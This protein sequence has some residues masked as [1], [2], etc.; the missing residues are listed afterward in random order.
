MTAFSNLST[1]SILSDLF[2]LNLG[3]KN[4]ELQELPYNSK[5]SFH[6]VLE[7]WLQQTQHTNPIIANFARQ[8]EAEAQKF[9]EVFAPIADKSI[10]AEHKELVQLL[11]DTLFPLTEQDQWL[12]RVFQPM[13]QMD[14]YQTEALKKLNTVVP[15]ENC[16]VDASKEQAFSYLIYASSCTILNKFYGM[17]IPVEMPLILSIK[18][19]DSNLERHFKTTHD[20]KFIDVIPLGPLPELSTQKINSLLADPLN[21]SAWLEVFPPDLFEFNGVIVENLIEITEE[22]TLS[23]IK[24]QL[25]E[26]DVIVSPKSIQALEQLF[27]NFLRVSEIHLGLFAVDGK[28]AM[29]ASYKYNIHHN[30]L[31]DREDNL[32]KV[33]NSIYQKVMEAG[34]YYI[35]QDLTN[36][37]EATNI[38]VDLLNRGI[39]SIIVVP[40]YNKDQKIIGLLELASPKPFAMNNLHIAKLEEII[41]LFSIAIQRRMEETDN[42]IEAIIREQYTALHPSVEWKFV[43]N[44]FDLLEKREYGDQDATAKTIIFPKVYP[45]FAQADI[46]HS[47]IK[48]NKAIQADLIQQLTLLKQVLLKLDELIYFPVLDQYAFKVDNFLSGLHEGINSNDESLI[49]SLLKLEIHPLFEQMAEKHPATGPIIS[50]YFNRL[51]P[52]LMMI[53]ED[54]KAYEESVTLINETIGSY[55]EKAQ[56][57]AQQIVPHYFE[58]YKTDG[59][60]FEIYAGRS[61]LKKEQFE[62]IHLKSLRL[63][64]LQTMCSVTQMVHKLRPNLPLPLTTAQ[65]IFVFSDPI[66]IRFRMDEKRFDVDGAY[67]VRYEIIKKRVDKATVAGSKERIREEGKIAIIYS[68]DKDREEYIEFIQYLIHKNLIEPHFEELQVGKLQGVEGLKALRI[69]V[70]N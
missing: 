33:Q 13:A 63:W 5:V 45:L 23:R 29:C 24:Y 9:P 27:K 43:A 50:T 31:A 57:K 56:K 22:L 67:N 15:D 70:K 36:I 39:R 16:K 8:I 64:Q 21:H 34:K 52:E 11:C 46:V 61:L 66:D 60:E 4:L 41:P 32:L 12:G 54:R 49:L 25:L 1:K 58:Q 20:S 30:L 48:R 38:E 62:A 6:L 10:L 18:M 35:V 19:P 3:V 2:P 51:D 55:L 14:I 44:A 26:K 37:E 69:T 17:N 40:L 65:M 7:Y 28:G 47:S 42:K 59:I 68:H 53:Y